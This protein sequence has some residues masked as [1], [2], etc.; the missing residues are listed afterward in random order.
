MEKIIPTIF[1][2]VDAKIIG[3]SQTQNNAVFKQLSEPKIIL[4]QI[5]KAEKNYITEI[6]MD[7]NIIQ[8]GNGNGGRYEFLLK[9]ATFEDA[10]PEIKRD[11]LVSVK[12]SPADALQYRQPN[13]KFKFP[14]YKNVEA[15][16]YYFFGI[17]NDRADSNKFNYLEILGSSDSKSYPEGAIAVKKTGETF[18][19]MGDFYFNIFGLNWKE[20]AGQ[21]ILLGTTLE[22]L[23]G[24]KMLFKYQPSQKKYSLTDLYSFVGDVSYDKKSQ[25]IIGTLDKE[26]QI[27]NFVYK[28][29]NTLPFK[30]FHLSAQKNN[31]DWE[32][33]KLSYSL[34]NAN[35]QEIL[36]NQNPE[37]GT[38]IFD[39]D[40]PEALRKNLIFLK[41]EPIIT[42][43]TFQTKKSV[44]YGIENL[45]IE[46]ELNQE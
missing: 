37:V 30:T 36:E 16:A 2:E 38:Q 46:A 21:K 27:S 42:D 31:F 35:W 43:E 8:Q 6:E 3:P 5:F 10:I 13:G 9:E 32:K 25:S 40:I 26:N 44:R 4:G 29:E 15:G 20:Y 22:D 12:F 24:G 41:I 17:N 7:F 45:L 28:F 39:Q 11:V 1:G 19:T 33:I 34:D 18:H 23:G 14:I